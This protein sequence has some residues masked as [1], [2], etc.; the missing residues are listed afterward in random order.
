MALIYK[1]FCIWLKGRLSTNLARV[2]TNLFLLKERLLHTP[3]QGNA[4]LPAK[5]RLFFGVLFTVL[6]NKMTQKRSERANSTTAKTGVKQF[7][8]FSPF[9]SLEVSVRDTYQATLAGSQCSAMA[10]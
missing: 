7:K 3:R 1:I 8:V 6:G 9:G 10:V 5:R 4:M 2:S